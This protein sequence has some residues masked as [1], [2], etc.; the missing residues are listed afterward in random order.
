MRGLVFFALLELRRRAT[1]FLP[2]AILLAG[3]IF[4]GCLLCFTI[5]AISAANAD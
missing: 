2:F 5:V 4:S 3:A 1:A